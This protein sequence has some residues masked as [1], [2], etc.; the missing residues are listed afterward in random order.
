MSKSSKLSTFSVLAALSTSCTPTV[1]QAEPISIS[2]PSKANNNPSEAL[3]SFETTIRRLI[4]EIMTSDQSLGEVIDFPIKSPEEGVKRHQLKV[5]ACSRKELVQLDY[6]K[7]YAQEVANDIPYNIWDSLRSKTPNVKDFLLFPNAPLAEANANIQFLF[8]VNKCLQEEVR[9]EIQKAL[10]TEMPAV[11]AALNQASIEVY[12]MEKNTVPTSCY[13]NYTSKSG[14]YTNL[15][16]LDKDMRSSFAFKSLKASG[17]DFTSTTTETNGI[18]YETFWVPGTVVSIKQSSFP[19]KFKPVKLKFYDTNAASNCPK[20]LY[21][22]EGTE[23]TAKVGAHNTVASWAQNISTKLVF[24]DNREFQFNW[25]HSTKNNTRLGLPD[26]AD[27]KELMLSPYG[28][29]P[30]R[31]DPFK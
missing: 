4:G 1:E 13:H 14:T 5:E 19:I 25:N 11:Q 20:Y 30:F 17:S 6:R 27:V 26:K 29:K 22:V 24:A 23:L 2:T 3:T 7:K 21:S 31:S 18:A 16:M 8:D 10:A 9:S 28:P 15:E 12:R